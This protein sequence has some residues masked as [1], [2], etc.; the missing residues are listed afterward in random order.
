MTFEGCANAGNSCSPYNG[1]L[2]NLGGQR[3]RLIA[4]RPI[5]RTCGPTAN[6]ASDPELDPYPFDAC[7]DVA[8]GTRFQMI[9]LT[10]SWRRFTPMM[11]KAARPLVTV[12]AFPL[13]GAAI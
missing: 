5:A 7:R 13:R 4:H 10:P 3:T 11:E 2:S 8:H 6:H 1:G 12:L 9:P